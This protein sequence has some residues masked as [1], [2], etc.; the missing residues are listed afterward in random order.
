MRE[1]LQ[2]Y[3]QRTTDIAVVE[4]GLALGVPTHII[5]SP[6]IYGL[7][8]G[9]FNKHSIQVPTIARSAIKAGQ[10]EVIGEGTGVWDYVHIADLM[11][12]YELVIEKTVAGVDVPSG[13][14][15]ILFSSTGR[16]SWLE[17]SNGIAAALYKL[18]AIKTDI[19]KKIDLAD[20]AQKWAGNSL[21]FAELG[22]A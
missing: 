18:G 13:E 2:I 12:L 20:A 21:L 5:M 17:L 11:K 22:F 14:K 7:G 10:A 16:Y 4:T 15:G 3:A 9:M 6:T 1:K 19:V 8:T